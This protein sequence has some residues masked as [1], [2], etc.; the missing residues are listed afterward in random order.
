[1]RPCWQRGG[2]WKA[3]RRPR[4]RA[5]ACLS[6]GAR[7]DTILAVRGQMVGGSACPAYPTKERLYGIRSAMFVLSMSLFAEPIR[8]LVGIQ[9]GF[10]RVYSRLDP[11]GTAKGGSHNP[12]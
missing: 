11:Y 8:K 12:G 2:Q 1:M 5:K 4:Q 7:H 6:Q 10:G 3:V 9:Y